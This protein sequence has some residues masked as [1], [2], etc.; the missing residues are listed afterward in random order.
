MTAV[1]GFRT[2][3]PV[4]KQPIDWVCLAPTGDSYMKTQTWYRIS[5]IKPRD[6]V[7]PDIK[8]SPTYQALLGRWSIIEPKYKAWKNSEEIPENGIAL[9][10]WSGVNA[11]I[12]AHLR[13]KG[14]L[15]VEDVANMSVEVA[16]K[17]PMPN[18]RKLPELAQA[19]LDSIANVAE[20]EEVA[21]LR[22]RLAA[23]EEMLAEATQK[24]GPGRPKKEAVDA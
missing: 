17:L 19:Y 15:T 22:E 9:A 10:A 4:G 2:S 7:D 24:R 21:E 1:V 5:K 18:A 12:A 16:A 11:E 8:E 6:D 3:Y 13:Q 14:I 20:Q 23:M